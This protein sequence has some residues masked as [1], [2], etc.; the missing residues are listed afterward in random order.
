MMKGKPLYKIVLENK[1]ADK[2]VCVVENHP[3][4]VYWDWS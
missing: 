1:G 4:K 3:M 2:S